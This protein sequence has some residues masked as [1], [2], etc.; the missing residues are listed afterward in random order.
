MEQFLIGYI[1]YLVRSNLMINEESDE[2]YDPR[3]SERAPFTVLITLPI[4]SHET[5]D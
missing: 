2:C 4:M 5:R 3:E 1:A